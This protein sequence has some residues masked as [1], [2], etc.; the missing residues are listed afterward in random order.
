MPYPRSLLPSTHHHHWYVNCFFVFHILSLPC[1]SNSLLTGINI[2]DTY[3][4][5][6]HRKII[7][8]RVV[9]EGEHKM[10]VE[11]FAGHLAYQM[12]TNTHMLLSAINPEIPELRRLQVVPSIPHE[13]SNVTVSCLTVESSLTTHNP[14]VIIADRILVGAKGGSHH[15]VSYEIRVNKK[16]KKH[17]KTRECAMRKSYSCLKR[18]FVGQYCFECELPLCCINKWNPDQDCFL[19]HVRKIRRTSERSN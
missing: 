12:I 16:G 4:L 3:K 10:P 18:K 8:F 5:F 2:I 14:C 19:D 17:R 6:E 11:K 9:K 7:N 1:N 15:Q 13:L